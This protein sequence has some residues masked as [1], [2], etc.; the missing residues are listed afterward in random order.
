MQSGH[1]VYL[2]FFFQSYD[3]VLINNYAFLPRVISIQ[4]YNMCPVFLLLFMKS[5]LQADI[6]LEFL[7]ETNWR[8]DSFETCSL[9][10]VEESCGSTVDFKPN[11]FEMFRI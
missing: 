11:I 4:F 2:I 10:L 3:A 8:V 9:L 7:E 5:Y 6:N 1:D